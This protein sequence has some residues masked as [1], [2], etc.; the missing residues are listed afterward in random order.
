MSILPVVVLYNIDFRETNAYLTLLSQQKDG[1][2][3]L[4]ENSPEPLNQSYASETVYYYH[5]AHNGGVS[6]AYNYGANLAGRLGD[7][8][9]LLLLD[10]DTRFE[11]DYLSKLQ[12]AMIQNPDVNLFVPQVLYAGEE[13]FSPIHRGLRLKRGAL[14]G[15]GR[16]SLQHY[17]P[18]NSGACIRLSA[19][20]Q[21]GGYHAAIR[22]DF[23]DFDFFSRLAEVSESF[24]RVDSVARQS[25]SNEETQVDRLFRRYQFYLE[26]A[27]EARKNKLISTMV[28]VEVM[29]HALALTCRTR[30]LRFITELIKR[31]K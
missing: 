31:F 18:V 26:G 16:Y 25:F 28:T 30:S 3:L 22:L 27:R 29:R 2:I 8:E 13:P 12:S 20:L 21:A 19:F 23:A 11:S 7:V 6:A 14:L 5:D 1:R 4:Y 9:A 15:E 17:L 24:Y 10:E